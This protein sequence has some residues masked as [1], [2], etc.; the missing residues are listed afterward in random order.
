LPETA[1]TQ[2]SQQMTEWRSEEFFF[3][4]GK[5]EPV[6]EDLGIAGFDDNAFAEYLTPPLTTVRP[7]ML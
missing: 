7:P 6:P 1:L 5:R 4:K 3:C 2:F